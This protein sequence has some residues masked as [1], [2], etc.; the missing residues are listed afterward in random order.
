VFLAGWF[1]D[2]LP[3]APVEQLAVIRLDADLYQSTTEAI[4]ALYPKLS[5][6]GYI[7]VDDYSHIA[8]CRHAVDDYRTERGITEEIVPVDWTAVY[9][10]KQG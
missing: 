10:Q 1:A 3:T 2:T 8:A 6:G 9:W 5:P 4:H 7:I